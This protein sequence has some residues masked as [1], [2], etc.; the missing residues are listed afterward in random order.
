M[1][2]LRILGMSLIILLFISTF[3]YFSYATGIFSSNTWANNLTAIQYGAM[4]AGDFN[5][6]GLQDLALA[7]CPSGCRKMILLLSTFLVMA[8][9][10][11]MQKK[12][13][14][15]HMIRS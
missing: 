9:L 3:F 1:R 13:M 15:L 7:G 11:I 5:N 4:A 14:S 8:A 12:T 6:D 10:L 2:R